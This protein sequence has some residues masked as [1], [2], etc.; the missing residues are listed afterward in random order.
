MT[1][2]RF[3]DPGSLT[4][5]AMALFAIKSAL[6]A[7]VGWFTITSLKRSINWFKS[8]KA[9]NGNRSDQRLSVQEQEQAP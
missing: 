6:Q 5:T 7:I 3:F 8:R 9:K 4:L 2:K 1:K